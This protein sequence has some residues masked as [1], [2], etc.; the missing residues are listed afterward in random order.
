MLS[1][2]ISY[3][4]AFEGGISYGYLIGD[5]SHRIGC[6]C[7]CIPLFH[8][9]YSYVSCYWDDDEAIDVT[10]GYDRPCGSDICVDWLW[11]CFS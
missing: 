7:V 11:L 1:L 3:L 5:I 6:V 4:F 2:F 8:L 9:P 10:F